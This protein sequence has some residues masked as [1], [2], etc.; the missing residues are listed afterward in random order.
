MLCAEK[1]DEEE[2]GN[3]E[4]QTGR[5]AGATKAARRHRACSGQGP[6]PRGPQA[7]ALR[8]GSLTCPKPFSCTHPCPR[9][10]PCCARSLNGI[11]NHELASSGTT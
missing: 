7:W 9:V 6:R 10:C 5:A 2:L 8:P 1:Q 4:S 3:G 11:Q